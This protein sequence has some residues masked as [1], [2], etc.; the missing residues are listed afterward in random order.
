[1]T[2]DS[3]HPNPFVGPR[4]FTEREERFF[5]GR[6]REARDLTARIAPAKAHCSTRG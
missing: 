4:T 3:L 2:Q 6:G 5:F 1:M